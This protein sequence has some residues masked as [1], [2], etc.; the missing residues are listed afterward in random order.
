MK[1]FI[2]LIFFIFFNTMLFSQVNDK[3]I[4]IEKLYLGIWYNINNGDYIEIVKGKAGYYI[5]NDYNNEIDP[6]IIYN[7]IL[8]AST[9]DYGHLI[10][11]IILENNILYYRTKG[12]FSRE[13]NE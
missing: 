6:C 10:P 13:E 12:Y 4:N 11:L 8:I 9:D 7:D 2:S 3:N 1:I 5:I